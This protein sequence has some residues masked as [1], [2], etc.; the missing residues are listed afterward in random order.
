MIALAP[1]RAGEF[2]EGDLVELRYPC[3]TVLRGRVALVT[4]GV[5][6]S[7]A[8]PQPIAF[9]DVALDDGRRACTYRAHTPTDTP[10]HVSPAFAALRRL[11]DAFDAAA[12]HLRTF[13]HGTPERDRAEAAFEA[14]WRD[15]IDA[16]NDYERAY[17]WGNA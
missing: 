17:P 13:P 9:Y 6:Q 1:A 14:A 15:V 3:G 10:T 8:A 16:Q 5:D 4:R 2:R 7:G 11:A 12:A